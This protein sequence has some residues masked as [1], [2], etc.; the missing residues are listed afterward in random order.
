[1]RTRLTGQCPSCSPAMAGSQSA[2]QLGGLAYGGEELGIGAGAYLLGTRED[3]AIL[4]EQ[5]QCTGVVELAV[6][7]LAEADAQHAGD[8]AHITGR[9]RRQRPAP[10]IEVA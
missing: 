5:H 9:R 1:M 8:G 3:A 7:E 10:R 6:G 2:L 4:V